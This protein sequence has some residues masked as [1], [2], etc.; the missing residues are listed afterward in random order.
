[1][2]YLH[3]NTH[4]NTH[5][6]YTQQTQQKSFSIPLNSWVHSLCERA[7]TLHKTSW[8]TESSLNGELVHCQICLSSFS[9]CFLVMLWKNKNQINFELSGT[10]EATKSKR[11]YNC[12]NQ[13]RRNVARQKQNLK[14]LS[15]EE[16]EKKKETKQN[17]VSAKRVNRVNTTIYKCRR[18]NIRRNK[19]SSFL[20]FEWPKGKKKL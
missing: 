13:S 14:N 10:N 12:A 7:F 17:C 11:N 5:S 19:V 16:R 1:M 18:R 8:L 6:T 9:S 15:I 20:S 2:K 3:T 4:T